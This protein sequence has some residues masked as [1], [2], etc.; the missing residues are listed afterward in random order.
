MTSK[1]RSLPEMRDGLCVITNESVFAGDFSIANAEFARKSIMMDLVRYEGY[2]I[3]AQIQT[4]G[5][6]L[7][8]ILHCIVNHVPFALVVDCAKNT[9]TRIE[10]LAGT[11]FYGGM[12]FLLRNVL[13][14][15]ALS[16]VAKQLENKLAVQKRISITDTVHNP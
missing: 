11:N 16:C 7:S 5:C 6:V 2:V 15:E 8:L 10:L 3:D 13:P 14:N 4:D 9:R 12:V 1:Q